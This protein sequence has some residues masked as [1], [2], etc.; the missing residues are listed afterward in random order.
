M[1]EK[2]NIKNVNH[3]MNFARKHSVFNGENTIPLLQ[4]KALRLFVKFSKTGSMHIL[5]MK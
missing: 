2:V 3:V 4:L 1:F 5:P